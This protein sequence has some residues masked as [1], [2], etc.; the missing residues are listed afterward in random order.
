MIKRSG[1]SGP[2]TGPPP[3]EPPNDHPDLETIAAYLDGRLPNRARARMTEHLEACPDCYFVF[4]EAAQ[5]RVVDGV[6]TQVV[7]GPWTKTAVA[8][9]ALGLAA[10]LVLIV[11]PQRP[12][13]ARPQQELADL[14]TAVGTERTVEPRLTGGFAYGVLKAPVRGEPTDVASP[15]VRIAAARIEKTA[16]AERTPRNLAALGIAYVVIGKSDEAVS[17]LENATRDAAGDADA[18]SNLSAAY[19]VRAQRER[20]PDDVVKALDAA[21][22]ATR[23]APSLRE[24]WFNRALATEQIGGR[25]EEAKKAWEDYLRIDA[26][27]AWS[28][29]ANRHLAGLTSQSRHAP[30]RCTVAGENAGRHTA[31]YSAPSASGVL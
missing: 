18:W 25:R 19:L 4:T 10:S 1:M 5:A 8:A 24:A 28:A 23:V 15:D 27:S 13:N 16:D 6:G 20:R 26:A 14:V 21:D 11:S 31:M 9:A 29:E 3:S 12:G 30:S 2:G 7:R 22:R 17:V